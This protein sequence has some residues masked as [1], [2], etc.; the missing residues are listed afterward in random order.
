MKRQDWAF[1]DYIEEI[2][3]LCELS[4]VPAMAQKRDELIREVWSK[5]PEQCADLGLT[6][7]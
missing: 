7:A 6:E 2:V 4:A 5:F 3:H 1:S